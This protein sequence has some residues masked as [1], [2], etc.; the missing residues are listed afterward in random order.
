MVLLSVMS[1]PTKKIKISRNHV[2]K[3]FWLKICIFVGGVI[4]SFRPRASFNLFH[5][6]WKACRLFVNR[7]KASRIHVMSF[8]AP[9]RPKTSVGLSKCA[10]FVLSLINGPTKKPNAHSGRAILPLGGQFSLVKP[11]GQHVSFPRRRADA[12]ALASNCSYAAT[13]RGGSGHVA[14]D[15]FG[16]QKSQ[17]PDLRDKSGCSRSFHR[18]R[19]SPLHKSASMFPLNMSAFA[20]W[21]SPAA[22]RPLSENADRE[23]TSQNDR[24]QTQTLTVKTR[25]TAYIWRL[26]FVFPV[27]RWNPHEKLQS[28]L[29]KSSTLI[30]DSRLETSPCESLSLVWNPAK[31]WNPQPGSKPDFQALTPV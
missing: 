2:G 19:P 15:Y 10:H 13:G 7:Q 11:F 31:Y 29:P 6:N 24:V 9:K 1:R 20:F 28:R 17:R 25:T 27:W 21:D 18:R 12:V 22:A 14:V 4:L 23:Q 8:L 5:Q 3:S 30:W 16:S 26:C